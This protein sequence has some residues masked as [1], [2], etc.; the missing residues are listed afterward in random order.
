MKRIYYYLLPL[1][2]AAPVMVACDDEG[3]T[4][5]MLQNQDPVVTV[6]GISPASGYTGSEFTINGTEFGIMAD[7][8]KVTMGG[9]ELEV[10][11]VSENAIV[12][13]VPEG[14]TAGKITVDVYGQTV[15]TEY[16]FDVLGEPGVTN[17]NPVY[18]FVGDEIVFSGHDLGVSEAFYTVLFSGTSEAAALTSAPSAESFAVKVPEGAVSGPIALTISDRNVNVPLTNGFTVLQHAAVTG[19]SV[20][21][22]YAGS[23]VTVNGTDLKP[24]LLEENVE[25]QPIRVTLAQGT[26][27]AEAVVDIERTTNEAIVAVLPADLAVGEYTVSVATSFETVSTETPLV[28]TVMATP[29]VDKVSVSQAHAGGDLTFVC[30]NLAGVTTDDVKVMFGETEAEVTSVDAESGNITV[31]VPVTLDAGSVAL[32][33][34]VKGK[35]IDLGENA[36]FTVLATPKITAINADSFL[37]DET[38]ALVKEGDEIVISGEGFGTDS[39]NVVL[40]FGETEVRIVAISDTEIRAFV[41]S[42]SVDGAISLTFAG[43][44]TPV[45]GMNL[46]PL[47]DGMDV[48]AYVLKNYSHPFISLAQGNGDFERQGEWSRPADWIVVNNSG[49]NMEGF[50]LQHNPKYDLNAGNSLGLQTDWGFPNSLTNGRIY[51]CTAVPAGNY[52]LT[53]TVAEYAPK[54][55]GNRG[56]GSACLVVDDASFEVTAEGSNDCIAK[57]AVDGVK[58][59]VVDFALPGRQEIAIGFVGSFTNRQS[60]VKFNSFRVEYMGNSQN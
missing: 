46:K 19:L 20:T 39:D 48:T 22:G 5:V 32:S 41:P 3:Q 58:D 12:V 47:V 44:E 16:M 1:L 35:S 33:L 11:S 7:A 23:E 36:L 30:S 2:F 37:H 59:I 21:S 38:T 24:D 60:Y 8:V 55:Q 27:V 52:R 42:G 57:T 54:G 51:Q 18:G 9:T 15:A 13:K 10:V 53:G 31:K 34:T 25:L 50:G 4:V 56:T 29:V 26:N 28:Y 49:S 45:M 6:T 14:A 40:R 17:V 43:I